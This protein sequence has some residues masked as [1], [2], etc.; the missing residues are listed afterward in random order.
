MTIMF[1]NKVAVITGGANGIGKC[2]A[3]EFRKKGADVCIIDKAD[4]EHFVGADVLEILLILLIWC[5]SFVRI[6]QDLLR[7]KTSVSTVV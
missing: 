6:K 7:V 5:S 3:E 1:Q 2:I 4:G